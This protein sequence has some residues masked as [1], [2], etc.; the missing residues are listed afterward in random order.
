MVLETRQTATPLD[1]SFQ[2][3]FSFLPVIEQKKSST[4]K[5]NFEIFQTEKLLQM[6]PLFLKFYSC[7]QFKP[8]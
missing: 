3:K 6:F 2:K 1:I 8:S 5:L 4:T 7:N